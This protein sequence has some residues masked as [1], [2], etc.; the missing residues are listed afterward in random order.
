MGWREQLREA[1][2]ELD[3]NDLSRFESELAEKDELAVLADEALRWYG[4]EDA[5]ERVVEA[6]KT[7]G[8]AVLR[9]HRSKRYMVWLREASIE[10]P[11][12]WREYPCWT[13]DELSLLEPLPDEEFH[14]IWNAK[15]ILHGTVV[16]RGPIASSPWGVMAPAIG[17]VVS[18]LSPSEPPLEEEPTLLLDSP[19]TTSSTQRS[20]RV[21]RSSLPRRSSRK[22]DA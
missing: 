3:Q 14:A 8:R 10:V 12:A 20:R 6:W 15:D 1:Y 17:S 7:S 5:V 16:Y 4:R 21:S 19:P 22:R 13:R 2:R 9:S 11:K 18:P